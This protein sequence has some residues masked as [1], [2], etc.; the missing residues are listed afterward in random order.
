MSTTGVVHFLC[1]VKFSPL[2]TAHIFFCGC[3]VCLP[4]PVCAIP[5]LH[6]PIRKPG[7]EHGTTGQGCVGRDPR[8]APV[9]HEEPGHWAP[10]R[11]AQRQHQQ[12]GP[13]H[14]HLSSE[15]GSPER[16]SGTWSMLPTTPEIKYIKCI[17]TKHFIILFSIIKMG[18]GRNMSAVALASCNF[19]SSRRKTKSSTTLNKLF[20]AVFSAVL[21]H[22]HLSLFLKP[23]PVLPT[24]ELTILVHLTEGPASAEQKMMSAKQTFL[25]NKAFR[26]CLFHLTGSWLSHLT[27][28]EQTTEKKDI[29]LARRIEKE[30]Y[31]LSLPHKLNTQ[32]TP[33]C[34]QCIWNFSGLW[35]LA[36]SI[37]TGCRD[38]SK[39]ALH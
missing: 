19:H 2:P 23:L 29:D 11:P 34:M 6:R 20:I 30:Y 16:G 26:L 9:P 35:V 5:G 10:P 28:M 18:G 38:G 37:V 13:Q 32:S 39:V 27:S 33:A 3:N 36:E 14:A 25:I 7:V 31:I 1:H 21:K 12:P 15:G 22:L 4:L 8:P 17:H 24:Q